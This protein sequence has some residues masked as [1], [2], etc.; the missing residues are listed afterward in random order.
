MAQK[1]SIVFD[2]DLHKSHLAKLSLLMEQTNDK[3]YGRQVREID[4]FGYAILSLDM[5][6]VVQIQEKSMTKY[7]IIDRVFDSFP[8]E[9]HTSHQLVKTLVQELEKRA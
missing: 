8:P 1:K 4:I 2:T 7:D 6:D 9:K 5:Q 3:S